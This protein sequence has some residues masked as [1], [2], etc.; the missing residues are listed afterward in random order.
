M[1]FQGSGAIQFLMGI[2]LLGIPVLIH[3]I[4]LILGIRQY[5]ILG[6]GI[7]GLIGIIFSTYLL[8]RVVSLFLSRKYT[9]ALGFRKIN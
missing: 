3:I 7:L 9:M 2:P 6:I 8:K 5:S 4:F 1:N